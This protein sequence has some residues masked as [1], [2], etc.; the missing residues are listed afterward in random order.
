MVHKL[1][2]KIEAEQRQL[3]DDAFSAGLSALGMSPVQVKAVLGRYQWLRA[4]K[5]IQKET[6]TARIEKVCQV[7]Q[8]S[9][10]EALEKAISELSRPLKLAD[11]TRAGKAMNRIFQI[12]GINTHIRG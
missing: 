9:Y 11:W 12:K 3:E 1:I 7:A 5:N 10:M 2:K 8:E 4:V 6:K